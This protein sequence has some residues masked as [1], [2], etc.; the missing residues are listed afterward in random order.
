[1]PEPG[2]V[3]YGPCVRLCGGT[4]VGISMLDRIDAA[5][6]EARGHAAHQGDHRQFAGQSRPAACSRRPRS[7]RVLAFAR[8][9]T[10]SGSCS[11]RSIATCST[12]GDFPNPQRLPGGQ[13]RV[14]VI[15]SLSKT[16]GM[17]GWRL[18]YLLTPPGLSKTDPEIHPALDLLRAGLRPGR[19]HRGARRSTTS[20]CRAIARCSARGSKPRR[21]GCRR[22]P[23]ST[24][25]RAAGDVLSVP[26]GRGPGRRS[27]QALARRDRRRDRA[28]LLIRCVA[29][30]DICAF[31]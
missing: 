6:L 27:R 24:L 2:W 3:S 15:D 4:P 23:A 20:W 17:T 7:R 18:G 29:A 13:E 14:F 9:A 10:I 8:N 1:M 28:G 25:Q 30:R 11:T 12:Q 21:D 16:F 26:V 22:C 19:R 5:A 31:L